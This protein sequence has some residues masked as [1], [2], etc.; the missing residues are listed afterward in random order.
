MILT[1]WSHLS[2][3]LKDFWFYLT[4]LLISPILAIIASYKIYKSDISQKKK[5][6][7]MILLFFVLSFIVVVSFFEAYFRYI[8]DD[9]DGLG[10]LKVNQKWLQRHVVY[11]G[12]YVRDREFSQNKPQGTTRIGVIG[13]SLTFGAGIKDV[14]NRFSNILE[15]KL[16]QSGY[17]VEVYNLGRPGL[18]TEG[19]IKFYKNFK[20]FNFD[21]LVWEYYPNDIQPEVGSTGASVLKSVTTS[22]LVKSLSDKSYFFDF[23]YWRFSN[24]YHATFL[25]LKGA[26]LRQFNTPWVFERHKYEISEFVKDLKEKD[27]K[28]LVVI[29][30]FV[31]LM[32]PNYP[33]YDVHEKVS[34][35]L[36]ENRVDS[37]ID[38]LPFLENK[39]PKELMASQFDSHPNEFVHRLTADKLFD[40]IV[41]ILEEKIN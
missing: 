11:N 29:F 24:K 13:D 30:P 14:R 37:V 35:I 38:M 27:K 4:L 25:K 20:Q 1:I 26:D 8:Y 36:K 21:I 18:D 22:N 3:F 7:I 33:A 41:P 32:G 16:T 10:F 6:V 2:Y 23:L 39:S 9:S 12:D 28:L 15:E 34:I 40:A 17:K 31:H 19:E 5:R